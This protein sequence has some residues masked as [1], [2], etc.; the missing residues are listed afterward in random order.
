M[1]PHSVHGA[2]LANRRRSTSLVSTHIS[3]RTRKGAFK[4]SG[5]RVVTGWCKLGAIK[6]EL[7]DACMTL[8]SAGHWL[9]LVVRGSFAYHAVPANVASLSAL[10]QHVVH[11]WRRA[12]KR[13]SQKDCTTGVGSLFLRPSP[14]RPG[15]PSLAGR[16][17]R[18][19]S[20]RWSPVRK[21]RPPGSV[22]GCPATGIPAAM[23]SAAGILRSLVASFVLGTVS[24]VAPAHADPPPT[25]PRI[26]VLSAQ[27]A[28]PT[29]EEGLRSGLRGLGYIEGADLVIDWRRSAGTKTRCGSSLLTWPDREWSS[30]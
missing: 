20:P 1:R 19:H 10:R 28:F 15:L 13:R 22:R 25:V 3:G 24:L 21:S 26:G 6:E 17:L 11:L 9:R 23:S 29:L 7:G 4:L 8:S 16:A 30:S 27:G 18:R 2:A 5:S 12:L 14:A